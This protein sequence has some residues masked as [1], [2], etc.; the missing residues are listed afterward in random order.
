MSI[1]GRAEC[2]IAG[3]ASEALR[4]SQLAL[5]HFKQAGYPAAEV[6][7]QLG[8][9]R[10]QLSLGDCAAARDAAK[11]AIG[12]AQQ[13]EHAQGEASAW[14]TMAIVQFS[15]PNHVDHEAA[16]E[17]A[18]A[19]E[20]LLRGVGTGATSV[21]LADTLHLLAVL[22]LYS[23]V[24]AQASSAAHEAHV[25]FLRA[26][27]KLGEAEIIRLLACIDLELLQAMARGE[28]APRQVGR[29][30]SVERLQASSLRN[31]QKAVTIARARASGA[32][33]F[34]GMTLHTLAQVFC[35]C[36]QGIEGVA[37]AE[38]AVGIF[39]E[40]GD[41]HREG[42]SLIAAAD[43]C[44]IAGD[45]SHR[46][47]ATQYVNRAVDIF[48]SLG[49]A[50]S[51]EL[52]RSVLQS[53]G[54]VAP[55]ALEVSDPAQALVDAVSVAQ[56]SG[57]KGMSLEE[58]QRMAKDT[59]LQAIGDDE[60]VDMDSPLMDIGLDSLASISFRESLN[61]SCGMT[62]PTSLV[63]D[64]PSLQAVAAHMVELSKEVPRK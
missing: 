47:T 42:D 36:R 6:A 1:S 64:Y 38:E 55:R 53:A 21:L 56:D 52:A 48:R 32:R 59:V 30:S 13:L 5:S 45:A 61:V 2:T 29:L 28:S 33:S 35:A 3:V 26:G 10:A 57:I 39:L 44:I 49:D 58:A 12:K 43:A 46:A 22:Y 62:L 40:T 17:S 24:P 34:L 27:D 63:F 8:V 54:V 18:K 15:D 50:A 16:H 37:A 23:Q 19:A 60:L 41:R 14:L 4:S 11:E 7:A 9:A 51:E 31:A 20:K 25:L